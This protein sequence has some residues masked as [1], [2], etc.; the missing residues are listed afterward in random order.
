MAVFKE[1]IGL[2]P[3]EWIPDEQWRICMSCS[4]RFT[5]IK[6]RHHCRA[7]GRVL[8]CDCCHLR[9]KLQYLEN[10][11]ARVCQLCAS[12]LDQC[13][14]CSTLNLCAKVLNLRLIFF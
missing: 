9:V 3:P 12:L 13:I 7:C 14:F 4:A 6:R 8:C 10:K 2:V 11:K 5:L 1:R